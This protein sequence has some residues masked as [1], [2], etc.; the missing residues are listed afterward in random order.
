MTAEQPRLKDVYLAYLRGETT[1][2]ELIRQSEA[3]IAERE[4]R[5]RAGQGRLAPI[6]GTAGS[7][8]C[9]ICR[10]GQTRPGTATHTLTR[11]DTVMVIR[12]VPAEICDTCGEQYFDEKATK[13]LGEVFEDAIRAGV[14]V[15]VREYSAA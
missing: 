3:R 14:Q 1:F 9:A 10:D 13:R 12:N 7:M 15:D 5:E 6:V 8:K 11:G 2:E 4:R